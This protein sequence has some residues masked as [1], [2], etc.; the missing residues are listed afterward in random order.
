VS[1]LSRYQ[2]S[3]HDLGTAR[4]N[5]LS[6]ILPAGGPEVHELAD[7]C[8]QA[9]EFAVLSDYRDREAERIEVFELLF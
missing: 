5:M 2:Q 6:R 9:S 8:A 1:P 4:T 7:V 3:A